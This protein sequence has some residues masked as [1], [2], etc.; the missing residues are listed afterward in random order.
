MLSD[1]RPYVVGKTLSWN[2]LTQCRA[3]SSSRNSN[4][5]FNIDEDMNE[6]VS[7]LGRIA[8]TIAMLVT[9]YD[10][11]Y[12]AL[13]ELPSDQ[14]LLI[15][16]LLK[17]LQKNKIWRFHVISNPLPTGLIYTGECHIEYARHDMRLS[18][19]QLNGGQRLG[20]VHCHY[21][22]IEQ[23][24]SEY[25]DIFE[26]WLKKGATILGDFN[27]PVEQ[28][29]INCFKRSLGG[30]LFGAVDGVLASTEQR[31]QNL[32]EVVCW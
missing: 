22:K 28:L 26:N 13:Q 6:Y 7:R 12:I 17:L 3:A 2:I 11:E 31:Y 14:H 18:L 24:T 9:Q 20:H 5:A 30:S 10:I 4:N 8:Q 27:T 1:H 32:D 19:Y 15:S 21:R 16:P 29:P 25:I 23:K